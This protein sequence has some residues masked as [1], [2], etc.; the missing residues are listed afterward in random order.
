M[1][2]YIAG[3]MRGLPNNNFK[4]FDE[5]EVSLKALYPGC[6]VVNP[7]DM[8]RSC[9]FDGDH[10]ADINFMREAMSR[11]LDQITT[12]THIAVL[13]NW[14]QSEG[15]RVEYA[16]AQLLRLGVIIQDDQSP[17]GWIEF[18]SDEMGTAGINGLGVDPTTFRGPVFDDYAGPR[19]DPATA[20]K[21][22]PVASGVLDYFPD[23]IREI[24]HCS[25][26][27][28]EQHNPGEPLHWSRDKSS[29]HPDC[30]MRHFMER[31]TADEDGVRHMTKAAWRALALLQIE[32]EG[33]K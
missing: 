28:N 32:L 25:W 27:G 1:K 8:D 24:A 5:A 3:P 29:D 17:D 33:D 12:C 6:E 14:H 7:A 20:R 23:A 9:G 2:I 26:V 30:M 31:G 22:R 10:E 11:D 19:V 16:L 4:A 13:D 18:T 21:Q 15:A